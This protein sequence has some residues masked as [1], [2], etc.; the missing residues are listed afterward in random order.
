[1]DVFSCLAVGLF[2]VPFLAARS[3]ARF[4]TPFL[5]QLGS[6]GALSLTSAHRRPLVHLVLNLQPG[7]NS[8]CILRSRCGLLL[9]LAR[10]YLLLNFLHSICNLLL[11]LEQL[12]LHLLLF[13]D[14]LLL[15]EVDLEGL[16]VRLGLRCLN[17]V[18]VSEPLKSFLL[19]HWIICL[20]VSQEHIEIVY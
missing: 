19:V 1:M 14:L 6:T 8:L 16:L 20:Y 5:P 18:L 11:L 9:L 15:L 13:K 12:L 10:V 3:V 4:G 2:V 7:W 17:A